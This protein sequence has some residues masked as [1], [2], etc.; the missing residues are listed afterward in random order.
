MRIFALTATYE[1]RVSRK[2]H[3][4]DHPSY[5]MATNRYINVIGKYLTLYTAQFTA[6]YVSCN[7]QECK[8]KAV[9]VYL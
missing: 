2:N 4:R 7:V 1:L 3:L 9:T 8:P 6:V 5:V